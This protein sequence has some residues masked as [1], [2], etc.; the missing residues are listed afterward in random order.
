[1]AA[2]LFHPGRVVLTLALG[3]VMHPSQM[4]FPVL[5]A[6]FILLTYAVAHGL[7]VTPGVEGPGMARSGSGTEDQRA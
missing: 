1:M 4:V 3:L 2:V 5:F 6:F 7:T